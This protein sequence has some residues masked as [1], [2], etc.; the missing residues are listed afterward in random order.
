MPES[1]YKEGNRYLYLTTP[2]GPDVLLLDKFTGTESISE[3]FRFELKMYAAVGTDVPFDKLLGQGVSF[4][5]QGVDDEERR[6][7]NGVVAAMSELHQ[8]KNFTHYEAVVVP[9]FWALSQRSQCRIFQQKSVPD[10]LKKVLD[11]LDVSYELQG[12]YEPREYVTQYHESD[13]DFASRLMEEE[14][15]F[16]FFKH[17]DSHKMVVADRSQSFGP[18]KGPSSTVI[19]E[20]VEGG[21]RE[22]ERITQ[23][24]KQQELR[25]GKYTL[26]DHN[27]Q[28]PHKHLEA[29]QPVVETINIGTVTHKLKVAGNETWEVFKHPGEYAKRFDGIS[30]SGGEQPS[31]L[32][33]IFTDNTRTVKIRAHGI[34]TPML[35][36]RGASNVRFLT[37]GHKFTLDRHFNADGSYVLTSVYHVGREGDMRARSS[38]GKKPHYENAFSC[39]PFAL[40][41]APPRRTARPVIAGAQTAVV[42]GPPGE[43][44]FTDK[45]GRVKAQFHW[46]REGEYNA[47]SSCWMRVGSPWAGKQWGMIHI[48]RIGQ[49]VIVEFLEGDPDRPIIVGS[50]YNADTMPPYALPDNKTQS[51]VRSRSSK[52]GGPANFNEIRF[53]DKKGSEQLV[54]HAEKDQLLEVEHDE[55]HWVGND[56][57]ITIDN[58]RWDTVKNDEHIDIKANRH[59]K[60]GTDYNNKVGMDYSLDSGMNTHIKSGMNIG[61]QAGMGIHLKANMPII[62]ESSLQVSLKVG[63]SFVDVGPAGVSITG[64][65]VLINS[66]GAAGA[67]S[68][69]SPKAPQVSKT[70]GDKSS[71]QPTNAAAVL[72]GKSAAISVALGAVLQA[73]AERSAAAVAGSVGAM[74]ALGQMAEGVGSQ[75][76]DEVKAAIAEAQKKLDKVIDE[77]KGGVDA[78]VDEFKEAAKKVEKVVDEAK[79]E[80]E[81]HLDSVV[82]DAKATTEGAIDA[83]KKEGEE[84]A[85]KAKAVGEETAK[86]VKEAEKD[87]TKAAD[88]VKDKADNAITS[89]KSAA[90]QAKKEIAEKAEAAVNRARDEQKM[91]EQAARQIAHDAKTAADQGE[92]AVNSAASTFSQVGDDAK[93]ASDAVS[94]EIKSLGL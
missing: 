15:I 46:D 45:Y 40:P 47:S 8:D 66:G 21:N 78:A 13:F 73:S 77:A 30:S 23:W 71:A 3:L 93:N 72:A 39:I 16:Y 32:N 27:F 9:R 62:L 14:G 28:L 58:D 65:L 82:K 61:V 19:Y 41:Y 85:S 90:A 36:I 83:A 88:E 44:I 26:W 57:I 84:A 4:G 51:G 59:V 53:E 43:E 74:Q 10:I 11:G 25:S 81:E 5:V 80:V 38:Q 52:G 63:G 56:Q 29:V 35:L 50:V 69:C 79:K 92:A 24:T 20:G 68:G 42:T 12:T 64:P 70:A 87:V 17:E 54:V 31:E 2:L 6:D 75:V 48:P 67:G 22:E 86:K 37:P 91:T 89:V 55:T 49:E 76:V 33:K 7:F 60:V 18:I 94:N 34:E 1:D